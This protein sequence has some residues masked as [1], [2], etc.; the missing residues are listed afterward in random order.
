VVN[1]ADDRV[2]GT[3]AFGVAGTA[4]G[5]FRMLDAATL[6]AVIAFVRALPTVEASREQWKVRPGNEG[7]GASAYAANCAKCHG[8]HGEGPEAPALDHPSF[9][10]GMSDGQ[11]AATIIRGRPATEM[12][13]FGV[14]GPDHAR[15]SPDDVADVVAFV[16][17][18]AKKR[19]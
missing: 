10:A 12:P 6:E 5:S 18:L 4:M 13:S 14:V 17:T 7:R 16:R 11:L 2:Y 19:L 1:K 8:V 3:L 9:Q 15:L